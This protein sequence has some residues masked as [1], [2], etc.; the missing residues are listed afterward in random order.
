VFR[1]GTI[2]VICTGNVCRS[3]Y[4]ERRLAQELEGTSIGVSSA[5]TAALVGRDMDPGSKA[6]LERAGAWSE[7][8]VARQLTAELVAGADLVI[9]AAREHRTAAAQLHPR[10]LRRVFTLRDLADLL[11][12]ADLT[13][14]QPLDPDA[15]WVRHVGEAAGMRRG[16]VVARQN[17]VDITDP[18]GRP[19]EV[20]AQMA[21]DIEAALPS[22]VTALRR[23]A[24]GA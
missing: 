1:P 15:A 21:A 20:F 24:A 18:I 13:R 8:F 11:D 10:A 17:D 19:P 12:G 2:L 22:V 9:T 3:P 7:G 4:L 14:S 6:L 23:S 5:G 16:L